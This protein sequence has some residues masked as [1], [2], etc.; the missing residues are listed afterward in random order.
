MQV[1]PT[2]CTLGDIYVEEG[3]TPATGLGYSLGTTGDPEHFQLPAFAMVTAID[4][5]AHGQILRNAHVGRA[6][7]LVPPRPQPMLYQS[8][9]NLITRATPGNNRSLY[10]GPGLY[11]TNLTFEQEDAGGNHNWRTEIANY[12]KER[13]SNAMNDALGLPRLPRVYLYVSAG[14]SQ[15]SRDAEQE[16]LDDMWRAYALTLQLVDGLLA[17]TRG[18]GRT[19]PDAAQAA[20]EAFAA[21]L[22]ARVRHLGTNMQQWGA[23]YLELCAKTQDRDQRRDH[24][25][26]LEWM[27]AADVPAIPPTF[28]TGAQ[29]EENGRVYVRVTNGT[30]RVPGTATNALITY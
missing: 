14:I 21:A 11:E 17:A 22:D 3:S 25:F 2:A 19:Q 23:K 27:D 7:G 6:L 28:L 13:R 8:R 29:R 18:A 12:L 16:H 1:N 26:G 10:V 9:F 15:R 4:P 5:V 30:T 24:S 20:N